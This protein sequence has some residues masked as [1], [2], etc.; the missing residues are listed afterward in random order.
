MRKL[1]K[2]SPIQQFVDFIQ[3]HHHDSWE[4]AKE[5]SPIWR[6]HILNHEQHGLSGYTEA[7]IRYVNSHIDHFKKQA[8]YPNLIFDWNNYVVDNKDDTYGARYKDNVVCNQADNE[9]LVNPVVE[10]AQR[11]FKYELSGKMVPVDGLEEVEKQRADYTIDSFNL[12]EGSLMERRRI[13]INTV[14]DDFSDLSDEDVVCALQSA[15]FPSVVEQLLKERTKDEED[16][17]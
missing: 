5:V 3:H 8:L 6:E 14:L 2:G 15:G 12:N 17:L 1:D 9:R 11:F 13:I 4:D 7:P 10:N 16:V